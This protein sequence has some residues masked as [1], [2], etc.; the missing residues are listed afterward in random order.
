[1]LSLYMYIVPCPRQDLFLVSDLC[2]PALLEMG[3]R[4]ICI[5]HLMLE[6][7]VKNHQILCLVRSSASQDGRFVQE[8]F[9]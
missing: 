9:Q 8:Q 4:C 1:M 6:V 2:T 5:W 3:T 7:S